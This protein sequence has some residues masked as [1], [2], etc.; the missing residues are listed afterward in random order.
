MGQQE[1]YEIQQG[2]MQSSSLGKWEAIRSCWGCLAGSS[3]SGKA[4]EALVD[5]ELGV[6]RKCTLAAKMTDSVLG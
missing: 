3:T 1:L 6:N 4:L 2:Q 5:S